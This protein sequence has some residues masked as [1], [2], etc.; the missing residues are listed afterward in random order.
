MRAFL[1]NVADR[2]IPV[3][4][5]A[6]AWAFQILLPHSIQRVAEARS[7]LPNPTKKG[8][9]RSSCMGAPSPR[10]ISTIAKPIARH[11]RQ[12]DGTGPAIWGLSISTVFSSSPA[13]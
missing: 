4:Y 11:L 12:T 6:L 13:G 2:Q 7:A 9:A 1:E 10:A 8:S 5:Q 3:T